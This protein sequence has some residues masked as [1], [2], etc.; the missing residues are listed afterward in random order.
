[1][2]DKVKEKQTDSILCSA[3]AS[4]PGHLRHWTT[5]WKFM[6]SNP[7]PATVGPLSKALNS[8]LLGCI[9]KI[10]KSG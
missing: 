9:N 3:S 1:M 8:Q 2:S 7:S 10:D 4:A 5:V 6:S